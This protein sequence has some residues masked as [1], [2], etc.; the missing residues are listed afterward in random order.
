MNIVAPT[1][2]DLTLTG[3]AKISRVFNVTGRGLTILLGDDVQGRVVGPVGVVRSKAGSS[4]F[5]GPDFADGRSSSSLA[6]VATAPNARRMF[7]PGDLVE[8]F[9]FDR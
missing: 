9:T 8:F 7:N 4:E 2:K 1:Q 6:V 3:R 5:K